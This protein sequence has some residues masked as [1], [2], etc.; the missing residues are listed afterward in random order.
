MRLKTNPL[1]ASLRL[2]TI[3]GLSGIFYVAY[4]LRQLPVRD[5]EERFEVASHWARRWAL[6]VGRLSGVQVTASSPPPERPVLL[7]PNHFGYVDIMA[8]TAI[9]PCLF[10][11]RADAAEWPLLGPLIRVSE[12][13]LVSRTKSRDLATTSEKIG[14]RLRAGQT[15]TV[16]LEGTSTGGD[17]VLPFYSALLKLA[18]ECGV[19]VVP[20]AITWNTDQPGVSVSADIAYWG[21]H[22]IVTHLWRFLG[23]GKKSAHIEFGSPRP[24]I[25]RKRKELAAELQTEILKMKGMPAE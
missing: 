25:G 15:V 18:S 4:L 8:L 3:I 22:N 6:V 7:C 14:Q 2:L 16:F 5:P 10:V 13:V 1:L 20:V 23:I 11:T 9:A 17:R 12:Q 24:A 21:E 19:P